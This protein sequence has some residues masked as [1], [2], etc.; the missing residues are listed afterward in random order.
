MNLLSS[1]VFIRL[2]SL[3]RTLGINQI[4]NR[5]L[6][7]RRY[8]DRFRTALFQ[9]VRLGD[10]VW[11]IGANVGVY[12]SEFGI[13]VGTS[14]NVLAFE[15]VPSC[16]EQLRA[17]CA[18][19]PQVHAHNVAIG[20]KSGKLVMT[21]EANPLAATHRVVEANGA[22]T[23]DGT[24]EVPVRSVDDFAKEHADQFPNVLKIDVEGH[25]GSVIKGMSETLRDPRVRCVGMEIHFALLEAR[26][27]AE[28]PR[29]IE[30]R[31]KNSGFRVQW[32]DASHVVAVR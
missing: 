1:P 6:A 31:L 4:V 7:T 19:L 18:A 14:G 23:S 3:T 10:T 11:D 20:D 30:S 21:I 24:I 16:F 8:E 17:H 5:V 22:S 27:E 25:E 28:A 9:N 29:M 26:Q 2:R 15:P 32:T 13:A 12:S